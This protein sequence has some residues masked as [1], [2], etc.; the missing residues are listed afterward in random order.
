M[1]NPGDIV[2]VDF[3]GITGIKRRPPVVVSTADYHRH[4]PD[5]ILG[6]ITSQVADAIT[7]M[8]Y[9]LQDWATAGLHR[10]SAFRAFLMTMPAT[11][12]RQVGHCSLR[13]WQ[14]I[15]VCLAKAVA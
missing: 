6:I 13:D 14:A 1:L 8:D 9:I 11:S 7:P 15:Q 4:R 5:V 10:V 2:T 3:P 12:A